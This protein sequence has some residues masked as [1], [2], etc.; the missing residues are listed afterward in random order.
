MIPDNSMP[1]LECAVA[2]DVGE[3]GPGSCNRGTEAVCVSCSQ[4]LPSRLALVSVRTCCV[5]E[6]QTA[7]TCFV[8]R[9]R[10]PKGRSTNVFAHI[11]THGV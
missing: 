7:R 3:D 5:C 8:S 4:N 6:A 1:G 10:G 11:C 2:C 9:L